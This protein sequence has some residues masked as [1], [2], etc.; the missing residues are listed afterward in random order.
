MTRKAG[1][2][3]YRA[4]AGVAIAAGL[5]QVW[6]NVAVG[7]VGEDN[8]ANMGFFGV[9]VTAIAC[10][11]VARLKAEDMARAM[12]ATA[13]VQALLGVVVATAPSTAWLAPHG[14][15]GI[16]ILSS[17]LVAMWLGSATLFHRAARASIVAAA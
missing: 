3:A 6:M 16:V 5:V 9:G 11:F 1:R 2:T 15:I 8:P 12:A 7:I 4:G 17:G 10:A 14:P 13:V